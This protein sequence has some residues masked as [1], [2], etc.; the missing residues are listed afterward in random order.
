MAVVTIAMRKKNDKEGVLMSSESAVQPRN[1]GAGFPGVDLVREV[2]AVTESELRKLMHDPLEM[3]SRV[4]QPAIWILIFAPVFSKLHG[5][6]TGGIRYLDFIVPGILAQG[7]LF[8]S[9]IYGVGLLWERDTGILQKYL[10]SPASRRALVIGK[11]LAAGFRNAPQVLV[12][13]ALAALASAKIRWNPLWMLAALGLVILGSAMFC[14]L[15]MIVAC[16]VKSRERF[17]GA[18]QLLMLPLFFASNAL[19]PVAMMP[20]WL[21]LISNVNPLSYLV[22]GL[23]TVMLPGA[24]PGHGLGVDLLVL[25]PLLIVF[26]EISAWL[27]P[28]V[29]Y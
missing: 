23:R 24:H 12:V 16:V 22:D 29:E 3:L 5:I 4:V 2:V 28:R 21:Q 11:S 8:V 1:W 10:V 6:P 27:Y 17:L 19:Y 25:V 14:T 18:N 7:V 13:Y 9:V 15:A 20:G 26:T